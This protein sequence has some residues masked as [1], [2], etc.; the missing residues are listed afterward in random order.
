MDYL[1]KIG[2]F[3]AWLALLYFVIDYFIS[4]LSF[5][6]PALCALQFFDIPQILNFILSSYISCFIAKKILSFWQSA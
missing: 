4:Q 6:L 1:V 2:I 3:G 5:K